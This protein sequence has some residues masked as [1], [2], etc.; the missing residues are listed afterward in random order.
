MRPADNWCFGF[1]GEGGTVM[2]SNGAWWPWTVPP[3]RANPPSPGDC[4]TALD[5][6]YL[7]TGAMYRAVTWAVLE[8]GVDPADADG[9]AK[10]ALETQLSIGTDPVKPA[11][12]R[13]RPRRV[14]RHPRARGHCGR[15][16]RRRGPGRTASA[17]RPAAGDHR[18]APPHRRGGPRHRLGRRPR[19]R[20][21]GVL[22][23]LGRG[24]GRSGAVPRTPR[25]WPRPP[26][27]WPGATG[28]TR[29]GRRTRCARRRRD[30]AGHHRHGHQRGG[31]EAA[32]TS[33]TARLSLRDVVLRRL[34]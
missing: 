30:R 33:G 8:A 3:D 7:D 4:A 17:C 21:E 2:R 10:I 29:A 1:A 6:A 12:R 19:C 11:L 16:R 9:V 31:R 32:G 34:N 28:S 25:T 26:P 24:P 20:P 27:T 22:D 14:R 15:L 23:R 5:G 18:R 13:Q